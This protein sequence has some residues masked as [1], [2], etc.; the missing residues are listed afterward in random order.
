LKGKRGDRESELAI[1]L[2][3]L[4]YFL[5]SINRPLQRETSLRPS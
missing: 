4:L 1:L 2:L 3:L 5:F